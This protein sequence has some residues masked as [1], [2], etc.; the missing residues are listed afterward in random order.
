M[1]RN[2]FSMEYVG[3]ELKGFD[4][5]DKPYVSFIESIGQRQEIGFICNHE[6]EI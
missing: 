5:L 4:L 6:N 1:V 3:P 2:L